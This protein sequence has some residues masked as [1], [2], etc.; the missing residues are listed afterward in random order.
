MERATVAV[1]EDR[2]ALWAEGV[3]ANGVRAERQDVAEAFGAGIPTGRPRVDIG[4]GAGRYTGMLGRPCIGLDAARSMLEMCRDAV[5]A[6]LLVQADME[7][8]CFGPATIDGAWAN[9]SYLHLP[10][11]QASRGIGGSAPRSPG[12]VAPRHPGSPG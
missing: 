10:T 11:H 12:R 8:L 2:G 7:A 4:C 6:A 5:P 9:M 1:Y 3:R